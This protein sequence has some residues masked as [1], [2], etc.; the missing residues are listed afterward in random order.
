MNDLVLGKGSSLYLQPPDKEEKSVIA[1]GRKGTRSTPAFS[2]REGRAR[3]F[4]RTCSSSFF[5]A[6]PAMP[7]SSAVVSSP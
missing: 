7:L 1:R 2:F 6:P 3:R 4:T 5:L